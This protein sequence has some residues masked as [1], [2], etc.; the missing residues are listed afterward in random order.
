MGLTESHRPNQIG[1]ALIVLS[2]FCAAQNMAQALNHEL[3]IEMRNVGFWGNTE[4]VQ[5]DSTVSKY[6]IYQGLGI[7]PE[8]Q[9]QLNKSRIAMNTGLGSFV[10]G[11]V[12]SIVL[13][14]ISEDLE[15]LTIAEAERNVIIALSALG[16]TVG[17]I[18]LVFGGGDYYVRKA[19]RA[20][21]ARFPLQDDD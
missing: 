20:Y 4:Y 8:S 15:D 7:Y 16:T 1:L 10:V 5:N 12:L 18:W 21:N 6:L 19:V 14:I 9:T 3:P 17:G 11:G 13:L 2:S